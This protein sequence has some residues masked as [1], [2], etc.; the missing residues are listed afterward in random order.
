MTPLPHHL[1]RSITIRASRDTV[2]RYFT[3]SARWAAWW[4]AGSTIDPTPGGRVYVRH[5]NGI[6]ASGAVVEVTSPDRI[7]FTYGFESGKPIAPGTSLVTIRLEARGADTRLILTHA[8]AD[9]APRDAHVQGWRYQLSVFSNVVSNELHANVAAV[10]GAWFAAW[11][12]LDAAARKAQL[13]TATTPA[14]QFR[15][16]YSVIDGRD[17][18]DAQLAAVH[19]FMPGITLEARGAVRQCQ[20]TALVDWVMLGPKGEAHG[21]GTNVFNLSADGRIESAVGVPL[22]L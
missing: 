8:F 3:D 7:V 15:D 18:L 1:D 6:E 12:E 10:V 21:G 22:P 14:V 17:E 4:G 20:G 5:P 13:D 2:F 9:E 16:R 11:N 19:R